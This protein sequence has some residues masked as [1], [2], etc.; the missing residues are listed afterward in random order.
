MWLHDAMAP[1]CLALMEQKYKRKQEEEVA[2]MAL[3]SMM[4]AAAAT[5]AG[6]WASSTTSDYYQWPPQY[7]YPEAQ[8]Q[9]IQEACR[10]MPKEEV[11][12]KEPERVNKMKVEVELCLCSKHLWR[13]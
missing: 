8:Q 12:F 3:A 11:N 13:S 6:N 5:D 10:P 7:P 9:T 1:F 2:K 4:G